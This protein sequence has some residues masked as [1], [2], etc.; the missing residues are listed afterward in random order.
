MSGYVNKHNCCYWAHN[1]PHELH[2]RPLHSAKGTVWCAAYS[3]GI[4]GPYFF[5]NEEGRTVT[6]RHKVMLETFLRSELHPRQQDLLWFQQDG[7]AAHTAEISMQVLRTMFPDRLVTRFRD[8]IWPAC[9]R[10]LVVTD[11]FL[12]GYVRS[13]VYETCPANIAELKQRILDFI[14]GIPKSV[15]Q[16]VMTAFPSRLQE[17]IERH[18]GHYQVSH[19][20]NND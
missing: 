12:W 6:V 17:C 7:A 18:G 19:S 16:R 11:Y 9:W 10:N 5:E 8:I 14:Q 3:H 20:N 2:E 1:N 13:K 4:I 15:L